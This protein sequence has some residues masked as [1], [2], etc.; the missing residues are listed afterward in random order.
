M[1]CDSEQK[2]LLCAKNLKSI[3]VEYLYIN[4]I[5]YDLELTQRV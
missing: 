2:A 1:T 5:V 4:K 3:G